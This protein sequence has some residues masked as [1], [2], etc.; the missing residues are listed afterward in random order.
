MGLIGWINGDWPLWLPLLVFSP[1]IV[2]L[3]LLSGN[4]AAR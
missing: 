4:V 2:M 3:L 1:F